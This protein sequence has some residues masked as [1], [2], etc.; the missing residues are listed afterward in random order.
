MS[1]YTILTLNIGGGDNVDATITVTEYPD[2][3]ID[4]SEKP[5]D[6]GPHYRGKVWAG[7]LDRGEAVS[8]AMLMAGFGPL[9]NSEMGREWAHDYVGS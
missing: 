5:A 8:H 6:A 9:L 7:Y 3:T 4:V 1:A 2:G